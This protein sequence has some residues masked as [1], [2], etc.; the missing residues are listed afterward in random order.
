MKL[1]VNLF[2]IHQIF[3]LLHAEK[4]SEMILRQPG[5]ES[6]RRV[7]NFR[8]LAVKNLYDMRSSRQNYII[9]RVMR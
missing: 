1:F 4:K 7:N 3:G 2:M 9:M 6:L 5:K 8:S